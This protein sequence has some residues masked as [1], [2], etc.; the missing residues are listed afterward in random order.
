M[1]RG[2]ELGKLK[3][4]NAYRYVRMCVVDCV[5]YNVD[6]DTGCLVSHY[7]CVLERM[8]NNIVTMQLSVCM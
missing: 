1:H 5:A 6:A 8:H 3:V 2:G 4:P 7:I